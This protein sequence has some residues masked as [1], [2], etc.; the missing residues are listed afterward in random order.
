[1]NVLNYTPSEGI[2]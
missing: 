2:S 1:M